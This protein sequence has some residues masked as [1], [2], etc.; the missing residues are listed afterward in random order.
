MEHFFSDQG[1]TITTDERRVIPSTPKKH[2]PRYVSLSSARGQSLLKAVS[3]NI[4]LRKN[5]RRVIPGVIPHSALKQPM[6]HA[7]SVLPRTVYVS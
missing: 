5:T 7:D 3:F 6:S 1:C 4:F 2:S